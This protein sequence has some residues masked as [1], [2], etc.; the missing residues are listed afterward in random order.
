MTASWYDGL[1]ADLPAVR[2]LR[3]TD[4]CSTAVGALDTWPDALRTAAGMVLRTR[5][6]M[7]VAW[8]PELVQVYND[9]FVPILGPKHPAMGAR[10]ADTWSE[11]YDA[12]GP[13]LEDV[14]ATGKGTWAEDQMLLVDRLGFL[15]DT[16]FT[17]SYSAIAD[18]SGTAEGVLVT[19]VETTAQVLDARRMR[20]LQG[21]STAAA[22]AASSRGLRTAL[23]AHL[24]EHPADVRFAT[25]HV[26]DG[27]GL[28]LAAATH[29]ADVL[30]SP[31]DAADTTGTWS[32]PTTARPVLLDLTRPL[33]P[34]GPL[35][36]ELRAPVTRA[37]AQ[38]V[39]AGL[40]RRAVLTVGVS[41]LR[42]WDEEHRDF[43]VLLGRH[44]ES[45]L[46]S[47]AAR[48]S[49][50]ARL[51]ELAALD[52]A[53]RDFLADVSHE[54]R[55]PL[56]LIT[57]P[58][59]LAV[60]NDRLPPELVDPLRIAQRST[61]RLTRLVDSLLDFT[62]A[63]SGAL[64]AA[65]EPVDLVAQVRMLCEMFRTAAE[66]AGLDLVLDLSPLP[67]P[68]LADP[69]HLE[70]VVVN[71]LSNALKFTPAGEVR[72]VVLAGTEGAVV[73]VQDTGIGIPDDERELVF[74]RFRRGRTDA[75]R[76]IE[77]MGIG[78][79]TVRTLVELG[80]GRITCTGRPGPGT[81]FRV[82]LP[83]AGA[84]APAV[85]H[86]AGARARSAAEEAL[87][88]SRPGRSTAGVADSLLP[89]VVVADDNADVR[90]LVAVVLTGTAR[91]EGAGDGD[92]ALAALRREPADLLLTDL[93]MPRTD[94]RALLEAVR[95][96][97]A[98]ST[99]PVIVF[100]A[101]AGPTAAVEALDAGADDYLVKP[102]SGAELVARVR[103]TVALAT[104]RRQLAR[105]ETH[106]PGGRPAS[107]SPQ[108]PGSRGRPGSVGEPHL[109]V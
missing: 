107:G 84:G 90:E 92:A 64:Q 68:V 27:S 42:R 99:L 50:R 83:W 52:R 77:G 15:E 48:E 36:A 62:R 101:H 49:E 71:L 103:S 26:D 102:F 3:A 96:D 25:L 54:F 7:M 59:Q 93:R 34:D 24:A 20:V 16:Y 89:R 75:A 51:E 47:V 19:A 98:L 91:V 2:L 40:G 87:S 65:P 53:K 56:A 67:G 106:R 44:V 74:E 6:P 32:L 61:A 69:G 85:E 63:E 38:P 28:R 43:L 57:A 18:E 109:T 11:V 9:A 100:S 35:A 86:P 10:L 82:V 46:T 66:D 73:E 60:D 13:M 30:G 4:W 33:A 5:F 29:S 104:A 76:S 72:V 21:L 88:W 37:F 41:P 45:A 8:G 55:T 31:R 17:F 105:L 39:D 23:M 12:V 81:V 108:V 78:L 80:G 22:A 14:R 97:P 79:S 58:L 95:A 1:P 94:G 70:T